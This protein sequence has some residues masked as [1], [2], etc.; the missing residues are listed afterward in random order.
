MRFN[1]EQ[2]AV[3]TPGT[4]RES[5]YDTPQDR[6]TPTGAIP[7]SCLKSAAK[8]NLQSGPEP[9]GSTPKYWTDPS[10]STPDSGRPSS[11]KT[12]ASAAR[13]NETDFVHGIKIIVNF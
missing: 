11:L 3:R 5:V 2:G 6:S 4:G 9:S 1:E 12:P 10:V 7:R 13:L 8:F